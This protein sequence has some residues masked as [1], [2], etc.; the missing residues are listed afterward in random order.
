[1]QTKGTFVARRAQ[2]FVVIIYKFDIN[3]FVYMLTFSVHPGISRSN[4]SLSSED[5]SCCHFSHIQHCVCNA[6]ADRKA[7]DQHINVNIVT[8]RCNA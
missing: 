1:M 3:K 7:L 8:A 2:F 4:I 6:D 5:C